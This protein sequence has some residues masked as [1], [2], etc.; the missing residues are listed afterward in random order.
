MGKSRSTG[1]GLAT[2]SLILGILGLIVGFLTTYGVGFVL[3]LPAVV[4]GH[5]TARRIRDSDGRVADT[6]R[7]ITGSFLGCLALILFMFFQI[8]APSSFAMNKKM[9]KLGTTISVRGL[10]TA[11]DESPENL[12]FERQRKQA[13]KGVLVYSRGNPPEREGL[14]DSWG[15]PLRVI[16][17]SEESDTL[18]FEY[19]G[20]SIELPATRVAI[21]SQGSDLCEGTPDDIKTW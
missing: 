19:G 5:V 20:K 17:T 3:G 14:F 10:L 16:L 15:N 2:A 18:R 6:V 21:A 8:Q 9:K 7:T 13:K 1:S 12:L 4:A 11:L